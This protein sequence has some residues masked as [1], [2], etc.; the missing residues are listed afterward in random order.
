[1]QFSLSRFNGQKK[2]GEDQQ[3]TTWFALGTGCKQ[4]LLQILRDDLIRN[5]RRPAKIIRSMSYLSTLSELTGNRRCPQQGLMMCSR[6]RSAA[7]VLVAS[8]TNAS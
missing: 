1:M 2:T 7:D 6:R 8:D 5:H 3:H 4:W